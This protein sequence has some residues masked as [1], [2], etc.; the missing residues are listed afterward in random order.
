[1][2][3]MDRIQGPR[4]NTGQPGRSI[5]KIGRVTLGEDEDTSSTTNC[6][7]ISEKAQLS[8]R[9]NITM[10]LSRGSKLSIKLVKELGL[11][12]LLIRIFGKYSAH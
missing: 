1:M 11:G 5:S 9:K 7:T 2:Q 6:S 12:I 4:L 3:V 10:Q 8:Q